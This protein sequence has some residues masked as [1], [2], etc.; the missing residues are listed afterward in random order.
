MDR[1]WIVVRF[2]LFLPVGV[3][4]AAGFLAAGL[5]NWVVFSRE[6][7]ATIRRWFKTWWQWVTGAITT[8][9]LIK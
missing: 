2:L 3:L 7:L 4:L 1:F 6:G 9:E 5:M 8:Y